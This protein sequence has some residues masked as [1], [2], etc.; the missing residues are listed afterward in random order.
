MERKI[1]KA[2]KGRDG[3]VK[4]CSNDRALKGRSFLGFR[5]SCV[6]CKDIVAFAVFKVFTIRL[7][8]LWV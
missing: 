4:F 7:E 1:E 3:N 8:E 6:F 2:E 5:I